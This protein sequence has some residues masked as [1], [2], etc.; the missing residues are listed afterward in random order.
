MDRNG[1]QADMPHTQLFICSYMQTFC[2][3]NLTYIH[4]YVDSMKRKG[5]KVNVKQLGVK[6]KFG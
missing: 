4:T 5:K 3:G 1:I 6:R 2:Q